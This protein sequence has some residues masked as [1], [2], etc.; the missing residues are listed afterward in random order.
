MGYIA[1]VYAPANKIL[2]PHA[3]NTTAVS[4]KGVLAAWGTVLGKPLAFT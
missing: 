4:V 2:G 1:Y 3:C